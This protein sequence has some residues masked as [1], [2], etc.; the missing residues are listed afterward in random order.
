MATPGEQRIDR[1][2][3]RAAGERADSRDTHARLIDAVNDWVSVHG[4]APT[5]LADVAKVAGVS[6]A[7]AYR[8]FA[9]VDDVIQGFVLRLPVRAAELFA[10]TDRPT[11]EPTE[12]LRNWNRS[13]VA[14][15]V[16]HGPLAVNLRSP[17]GFLERRDNNDPVISYACSIIEPILEQLD[18]DTILQLFTWNVTSD[19]REVLDLLR[20]G[21]TTD[22]IV[23]FVTN[24]ILVT[25]DRPS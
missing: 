2:A 24:S 16:E 1:I 3:G 4:S 11:V 13:W 17:R 6:T 14:S 25:P 7:T 9:S 5:R 19:P 23:E 21:W 8:H 18:G 12:R 22:E 15:C 20:L 10:A